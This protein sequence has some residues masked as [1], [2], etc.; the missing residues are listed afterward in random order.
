M[1]SLSFLPARTAHSRSNLAV[2]STPRRAGLEKLTARCD[3][4]LAGSDPPTPPRRGG[5]KDGTEKRTGQ[6][7]ARVPRLKRI[8]SVRL[9]RLRTGRTSKRD[10]V[11]RTGGLPT[12]AD[13]ERPQCRGAL[14]GIKAGTRRLTYSA[15]QICFSLMSGAETDLP[16]PQN[17]VGAPHS[18]GFCHSTVP[19]DF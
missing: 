5:L 1:S 11:S 18:S 7:T 13:R 15:S 16:T 9:R 10:G 14:P 17:L 12:T 3:G 4:H 6:P 2:T 19:R 8:M